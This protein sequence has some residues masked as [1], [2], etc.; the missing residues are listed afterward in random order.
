LA[1]DT[2]GNIFLAGQ[3]ARSTSR[4]PP[5]AKPATWMLHLKDEPGRRSAN[6]RDL[7]RRHRSDGAR[8]ACRRGGMWRCGNHRVSRFPAVNAI[9]R[10]PAPVSAGRVAK[11]TTGA[12]VYSTFI[13]GNGS[14]WVNGVAVDAIGRVFLV[15][16]TNS[17]DLPA[18]VSGSPGSGVILKSVDGGRTWASLRGLQSNYA[19]AIAPDPA[20]PN[21]LYAGVDHAFA[22]SLDA[23]AT[24]TST[25]LPYEV[26]SVTRD[27]TMPSAAY[28]GLVPG[29][30]RTADS[31][32]TFT[33]GGLSRMVTALLSI[34]SGRTLE[35]RRRRSTASGRQWMADSTGRTRCRAP[36]GPCPAAFRLPRFC[37]QGRTRA[38]I[39]RRTMA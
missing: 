8:D 15:G 19:S 32:A 11:L 26:L 25:A 39:S 28:L 12:I 18:L 36:Y 21:V 35:S 4:T 24:W 3:T 20:H 27:P 2:D 22:V 14:D 38:C 5:E 30:L 23:G 6:L 13:G 17:S 33:S 37:T 1:T 34:R 29:L 10:R 9:D 31:G 7:H 16:Q